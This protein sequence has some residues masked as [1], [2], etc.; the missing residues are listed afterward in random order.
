MKSRLRQLIS[1][2]GALVLAGSIAEAAGTSVFDNTRYRWTASY[3]SA[4]TVDASDP[5]KVVLKPPSLDAMCGLMSGTG[6]T[7]AGLEQFADEIISRSAALSRQETLIVS[8]RKIRF[9][10]GKPGL[11]FQ[12]A[13][14][15]GGMSLRTFS[16]SGA[17]WV[18]IDCETY[19]G[20]FKSFAEVFNRISR[21]LQQH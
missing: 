20:K 12:I 16:L 19:S 13:L 6:W 8:R 9:A 15:P 1:L 5:A 3:P 4:W 10:N 21:S 7:G 18:V 17:E 14:V 11:Q 2:A